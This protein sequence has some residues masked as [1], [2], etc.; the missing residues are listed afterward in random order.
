MPIKSRLMWIGVVRKRWISSVPQWATLYTQSTHQPLVLSNSP[1]HTQ[2]GKM[3]C[4]RIINW[5]NLFFSE[6]KIRSLMTYIFPPRSFELRVTIIAPIH[7]I[8]NTCANSGPPSFTLSDEPWSI[9]AINVH[10][11][12]GPHKSPETSK[13][14]HFHSNHW[15]FS[16]LTF[17]EKRGFFF[18]IQYMIEFYTDCS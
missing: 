13:I 2:I 11:I 14:C 16:E 18:W 7:T 6:S 5:F 15:Q 3:I 4:K 9:V 12:N 1:I 8:T 10:K 17:F